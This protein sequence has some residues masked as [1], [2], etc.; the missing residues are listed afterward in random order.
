ML[1]F[2]KD[3]RYLWDLLLSQQVQMIWNSGDS[4]LTLKYKL[5]LTV[6][7]LGCRMHAIYLA[8]RTNIFSVYSAPAWRH[9]LQ[10]GSQKGRPN[11]FTSIIK[12]HDG[13]DDLC[14]SSSAA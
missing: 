3:Y 13:C 8:Y 12:D 2:I 9:L 4:L 7:Q 1:A 14:T 6:P 10:S 5:T 11:F